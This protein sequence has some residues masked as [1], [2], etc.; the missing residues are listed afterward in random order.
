MNQHIFSFMIAC[1]SGDDCNRAVFPA[2]YKRHKK[3]GYHRN[4]LDIPEKT[5]NASIPPY[6]EPL[7]AAE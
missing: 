1:I 4:L 7:V 3:V 5:T 6:P 2:P